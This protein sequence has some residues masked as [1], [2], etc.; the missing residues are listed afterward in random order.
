MSRNNSARM[1]FILLY[2][3]DVRE[4][5]EAYKE[6]VRADPEAAAFHITEGLSDAECARLLNDLRAERR[7]VQQA[8]G[9]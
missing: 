7:K 4:H 2:A 5:P 6:R 1:D 3:C 9:S 8:T